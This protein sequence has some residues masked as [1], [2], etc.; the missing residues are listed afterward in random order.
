MLS[1]PPEEWGQRVKA[2]RDNMHA[3]RGETWSFRD[4]VELRKGEDI[5]RQIEPAVWRERHAACRKAI[6]TLARIFAE[7][8]PDFAIIVGNDQE[9]IFRNAI[10][11]ALSVF[12]GE[13]IVNSM[14][15]AERL[16]ALPPGIAI[17]MPGY[18]PPGGAS[19]PGAPALGE[20]II[21]SLIRDAFDVTA[22]TQLPDDETPH[23]FGFVYRQIMLDRPVPSV[24]LILNTFYPPNQP[25]VE[26]CCHLGSSLAKA[27][28]SWK[29]DARV[30]LIASGG[31][32]HF[33]IDEDVDRSVFNAMRTG[34]IEDVASL[35]EPIFQGG[36]SEVKNWIPVAAAMTALGISFTPVDYIPCY[37]SEAGTGNA[38]GFAYWQS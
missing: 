12:W 26:R 15:S 11:P 27:I 13:T 5:A 36:T 35:G 33:V 8:R 24:P 19:Y 38:M 7:A 14:M 32:S 37:R 17:S 10:T 23:A 30:A 1:T 25:T 28:Q 34:A 20:H 16:A 22:L 2:D 9:E 6:G 21:T 3:F 31:L 4:L 18:I 29:G